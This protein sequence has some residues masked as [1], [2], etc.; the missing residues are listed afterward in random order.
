M[1]PP[2][3]QLEQRMRPG[4][5]SVGGFLGMDES[6]EAVLAADA[7]SL[8]RLNL[9]CEALAERL[10]SILH[11][12]YDQS[13]KPDEYRMTDEWFA[14]ARADATLHPLPPAELG[15]LVEDGRFQVFMIQY[16]GFQ[17]CPWDCPIDLGWASFDFLLINRVR[18]LHIMAPA[19]IVHL[20]NEH[21]F[22][23]GEQS[24]YRVEPAQLARVLELA[25]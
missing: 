4:E 15:Y 3:N 13:R 21:H 16:R 2:I 12:V 7:L 9:S 11:V 14:R 8:N 18:G 25:D 10:Q 22:F 17:L 6:L 19:L 20:I 1:K 5:Y 23:E 24:P